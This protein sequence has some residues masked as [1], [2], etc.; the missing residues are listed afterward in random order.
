MAEKP[1][2]E[3]QDDTAQ[4]PTTGPNRRDLLKTSVAGAAVGSLGVL[5]GQVGPAA[6]GGPREA[7]AGLDELSAVMMIGM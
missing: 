3:H 4:A 5:S 2:R 7:D 1:N 6:A